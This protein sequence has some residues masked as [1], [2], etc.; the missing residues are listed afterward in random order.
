[1][2]KD[3]Q[4][5]IVN[6]ATDSL[7]PSVLDFAAR[8][9]DARFDVA[10]LEAARI[11]AARIEAARIE[12]ARIEAARIEALRIE[13]ARIGA[14]DAAHL[15]YARKQSSQVS[16]EKARR[17]AA[18]K[19]AQE[20]AMIIH[21]EDLNDGNQVS[22]VKDIKLDFLGKPLVKGSVIGYVNVTQDFLL[23][24]TI[25]VKSVSNQTGGIM[26]FTSTG[27]NMGILGTRS[28]GIWLN[29]G[30]SSLMIALGSSLKQNFLLHT[31]SLPIGIPVVVS[32]YAIDR[33]IMVYFDDKV[34]YST[35]N[36][37]ARYEGPALMYASDPFYSPA[38]VRITTFD[39]KP[40]SI[41]EYFRERPTESALKNTLLN[42]PM[43]KGRSVGLLQVTRNF[44]MS[45]EINIQNVT[46][47]FGN[48]L[49]LT[50]VR[51]D[52]GAFGSR[53]PGI[54]LNPG[55]TSLLIGISTSL[56]GSFA[57][58]TPALP[59][60]TPTL[61]TLAAIGNYITVSYDR[62]EVYSAVLDGARYEG[63]ANLFV[64]SPWTQS[65][66]PSLSTPWTEPASATLS[67]FSFEPYQPR[68]A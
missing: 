45:F 50:S 54:W 7:V 59:L 58:N 4:V 6:N 34:V 43:E 10:L 9:E 3:S 60:A 36:N 15:E 52:K 67:A 2:I 25:T 16:A 5:V 57:F 12:A 48:V 66:V 17:Q 22:A 1:L 37:D 14:L 40:V 44:I 31:P 42:R 28:P 39:F 64:S 18:I 47:G 56:N 53:C 20:A 32:L 26:H 19:E 51:D 65:P 68:R 61:V 46:T 27:D 41:S 11:E 21:Y 24:L 63:P 49:L 23:S 35:V 33:Y 55:N 29:S 62:K 8:V 30:K 38:D 13:A